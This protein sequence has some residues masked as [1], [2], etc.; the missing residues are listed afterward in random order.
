MS[1]GRAV[2]R[3]TTSAVRRDVA[4]C[5]G[6]GFAW[7]AVAVAVPWVLERAVDDGVVGGDRRALWLWSAVI[8]ALGV[9]RWVGDAAR[10]W[11]VERAG[12]HAADHLRR[13]LVDRL[14]GMSDD[15]IARFGHGDLT[16]RAVGDTDKVWNWVSSIATFA[17][18]SFTLLAVMVLLLVTVDPM[19]AL[20]GL[21]TVPVAA[22]F[23]VRQ[24]GTHGRAAAAT[25][26][27]AGGYAGAVESSIGGVRTVKGLGA[28]RV[29]L[30][31]ALTAS[32]GLRV[33]VLALARVEASWL[34]VAAAIPAGGIAVGLWVG[35]NRVLDGT[36]TVGALVAFAAWMGLLVDA[37]V[38]FTSRLTARGEALA[39]ADRLAELLHCHPVMD[40][41]GAGPEPTW[42]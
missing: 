42:W 29:V 37:T 14:L 38:T 25:A 1:D 10:H 16:A 7:Q 20:V 9:V 32:E 26:A 31:R 39:A 35:G 3:E 23:S 24:V 11:W 41:D 28:E 4:L 5:L 6:S 12:A 17:T 22:W 21:A 36:I 27:G 30:E 33:R 15:E 19:L 2:L 13:R 8:V 18:A 34:A 40:N